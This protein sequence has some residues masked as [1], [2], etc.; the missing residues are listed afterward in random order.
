MLAKSFGLSGIMVLAALLLTSFIPATPAKADDIVAGPMVGHVTDK[1]ARVWMQLSTSGELSVSCIEVDSGREVSGVKVD[2]EGGSPFIFDTPLNNLLPNKNYRIEVKLDDRILKLPEPPLVI[3]TAPPAGEIATFN[4]AFGSC[5]NPHGRGTAPI[6]KAV[7]ALEPRAFLFLG[8]SGYLPAKEEAFP[9]TRRAAFRFFCDLHSKIKTEPDLQQLFHS[10]SC[11]GIWDDHDFGP[12]D[13]NRTWV[14]AKESQSAFQRFWANPDWG[15]PDN[16]GC[17]CNFSI[18]DVD[19]FLLDGRMYRDPE[20]DPA[21]KTMLGQRQLE[22]L[23]KGL[24]ASDATFKII[25]C[26]SQT[27]ADYSKSDSWSHYPDEQQDFIK[28]LHKNQIGGVLFISGNRNLG[29]LTIKKPAGGDADAYPLVELTSS[30][31]AAKPAPDEVLAVPNP[32]RSGD[33][34]GE[35]NFGTL[36]FGG[37]RGKRFVTLRLRDEAGKI[38]LEQT[39][40]A[41]QL[42]SQ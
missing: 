30:P 8:N 31:L 10:A 40:F 32:D 20:T 11:Y 9:T 28:W 38:K 37:P 13:S 33:A 4:I 3:R 16:P 35:N 14:Y 17:Y 22:W 19:F 5:M 6:F 41:G 2:V 12:N 29:E 34:V 25:A 24:K 26:G 39:V 18:S 7:T 1:S 42:H 27:I 23:K 15:E 36:D 21:R